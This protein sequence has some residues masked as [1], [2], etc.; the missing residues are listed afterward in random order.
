MI[1]EVIEYIIDRDYQNTE[2]T[3]ITID[4]PIPAYIRFRDSLFPDL[5]IKNGPLHI[6]YGSRLIRVVSTDGGFF[7]GKHARFMEAF[8]EWAAAQRQERNLLHK[9]LSRRDDRLDHYDELF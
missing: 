8:M 3:D 9:E 4:I 2:G 7:A 5:E 6:Q 1:S